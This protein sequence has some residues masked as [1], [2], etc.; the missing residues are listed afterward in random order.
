MAGR[1]DTT[2]NNVRAG[3]LFPCLL[4]TNVKRE[5]RQRFSFSILGLLFPWISVILRL[6]NQV[7]LSFRRDVILD[8]H[9]QSWFDLAVLK[10]D[11]SKI[12]SLLKPAAVRGSGYTPS[13]GGKLTPLDSLPQISGDGKQ[14]PYC[15]STL[16]GFNTTRGILEL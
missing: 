10:L 14:H 7:K 4:K 2:R 12:Q 9:M 6:Q 15:D 3:T 1:R 16:P 8:P 11:S 13:W 5:T